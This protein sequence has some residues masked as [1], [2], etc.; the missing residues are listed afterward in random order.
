MQQKFKDGIYT[1]L[2]HKGILMK[3][4]FPCLILGKIQNI[5][6]DIQ[7]GVTALPDDLQILPLGRARL[8]DIQQ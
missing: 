7:K 6:D 2:Q 8:T 4:R 5:I 3:S 1:F